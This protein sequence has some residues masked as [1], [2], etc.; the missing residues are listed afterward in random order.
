MDPQQGN[1]IARPD[2]PGGE[3]GGAG[4]TFVFPVSFAQ[5]RLWFLDQLQPG[6]PAYHTCVTFRLSGPLNVPAWAHSVNEL[7]RRH[8]AL[9]TTFD[10]V[11]GEP[12]QVIAPAAAIDVPVIDLQTWPDARREDEVRRLATEEVRRPFD[13]RTGPLLR[14]T[15]LRLS[16]EEHVLI[17]VVH[18]I[19]F[20]GWS[21]TILTRELS[22]L[23]D[24]F[25]AGKPSPLSELPIQY[26]D[27]AVWERGRLQGEALQEHLAYWESQLAGAGALELPADRPRPTVQGHAGASLALELPGALV[28]ALTVLGRREGATLFM[29][30]LAAF[31][32]LLYRYTGQEDVVGRVP[33]SPTAT[34][35][36]VEGLIGFFVNM[37]A[38]APDLGGRPDVFATAGPCA[39]SVPGGL[40]AAGPAVRES[41]GGAESGAGSEPPAAISGHVRLQNA[42]R[43]GRRGDLRL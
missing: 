19:V 11:G 4:D 3:S 17:L 33:R 21:G 35:A 41:G 29:T 5:Q 22:A 6:S 26:P 34:A 14:C 31:Q 1:G 28:E 16:E 39:R 43:P 12:V 40:R 23:Y 2:A 9:R 8:E 24:A 15:L 18:H 32:V 25:R 36:E 30:L 42:P 27:F 10:V 7:A 20:D 13:L 37:L 38:I